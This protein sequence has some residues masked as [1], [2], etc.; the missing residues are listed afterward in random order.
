MLHVSFTLI[1]L[2]LLYGLTALALWSTRRLD[3]PRVVVA[4]LV[5]LFATGVVLLVD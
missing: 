1:A 3:H 2:A 5:A 4:A